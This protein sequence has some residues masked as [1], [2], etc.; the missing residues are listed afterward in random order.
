[1]HA[2]SA[3]EAS[4]RVLFAGEATCPLLYGTVHGALASGLREAHRIFTAHHTF[5]TDRIFATTSAS[6]NSSGSN[7]H[8]RTV[9][10]GGGVRDG[11]WFARPVDTER[12]RGGERK[13]WG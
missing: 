8:A 13:T 11:P 4:E 5:T 3:P 9:E 12:E 1:M 10:Q 7:K 2:L 6:P